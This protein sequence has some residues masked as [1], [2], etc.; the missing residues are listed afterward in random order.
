MGGILN[1]LKELKYIVQEIV[2]FEKYTYF[3][4]SKPHNALVG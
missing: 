2:S 3:C 1:L 4:N